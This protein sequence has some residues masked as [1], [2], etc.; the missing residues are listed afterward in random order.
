M[1]IQTFISKAAAQQQYVGHVNPAKLSTHQRALHL[2]CKCVSCEGDVELHGVYDY[3]DEGD[4]VNEVPVGYGAEL[5]CDGCSNNLPA[6]ALLKIGA[7]TQD[8]YDKLCDP[9][10]LYDP[11]DSNELR[12]VIDPIEY[13]RTA[14][15]QG[16]DEL[17]GGHGGMWDGADD[18]LPF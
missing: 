17:P 4:F 3:V 16:R 9:W 2:E 6:E 10:D 12:E 5:L 13:Q 18:E 1:N 15:E 8:E 11:M 14:M 7:I